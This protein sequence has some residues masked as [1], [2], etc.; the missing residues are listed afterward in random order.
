M[1]NMT[2]PTVTSTTLNNT[3]VRFYFLFGSNIAFIG[4]Q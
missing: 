2:K 3:I 1:P 4:F